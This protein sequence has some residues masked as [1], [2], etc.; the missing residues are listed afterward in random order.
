MAPK[1]SQ[2]EEAVAAGERNVVP[3]QSWL[4]ALIR[5]IG[6]EMMENSMGGAPFGQATREELGSL[7][8]EQMLREQYPEEFA[9]GRLYGSEA[10][11]TDVA[12]SLIHIS[13]PTRPY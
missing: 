12:L 11:P 8:Y 1:R 7:G 6:R 2:Q 9:R 5:G 13:E 3:G 4:A 10:F